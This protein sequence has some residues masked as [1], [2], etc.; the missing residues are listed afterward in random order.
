MKIEI[1]ALC[2]ICVAWIARL[3]AAEACSAPPA[4]T[5]G[6]FAAAFSIKGPDDQKPW[7]KTAMREL[8]EYLTRRVGAACVTVGGHSN[9]VFHVGDSAFAAEMGLESGRMEN[10]AWVIR[11]FG[12]NVVLT[13]GGTRG[14]L[15]AVYHFLED[16]CG[17]RW[18]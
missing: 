11:S 5:E 9:V 12:G 10:E 6:A 8:E 15:Y 7:E 1:V 17:V 13:G 16:F 14:C 4:A 18:S 3:D 2:A